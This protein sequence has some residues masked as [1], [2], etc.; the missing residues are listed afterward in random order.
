MRV[1]ENNNVDLE[2]IWPAYNRYRVNL[3]NVGSRPKTVQYKV[4]SSD[5]KGRSEHTLTDRSF[6]IYSYIDFVGT[7]GDKP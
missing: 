6:L 7:M 4:L 2:S 5:S 3:F 1:V